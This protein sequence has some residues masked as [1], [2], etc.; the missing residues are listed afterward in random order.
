VRCQ[1]PVRYALPVP[2][3]GNGHCRGTEH[4]AEHGGRNRAHPVGGNLRSDLLQIAFLPRYPDD[5]EL[6]VAGA[7]I[8]E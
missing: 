4:G 3:H 6:Q 2:R 5:E 8:Y 1:D 7:V